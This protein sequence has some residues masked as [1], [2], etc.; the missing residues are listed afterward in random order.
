[1]SRLVLLTVYHVEFEED[2]PQP[3]MHI[4][5]HEVADWLY[6]LCNIS[7]ISRFLIEQ[8]VK[9]LGGQVMAIEQVGWQYAEGTKDLCRLIEMLGK[10][11][12]NNQI[13]IHRNSSGWEARGF[14][15]EGKRYWVGVYLAKPEILQFEFADAKPN[16]EAFKELGRGEFVDGKYVFR[17]QLDSEP[18]HFFARTKESQL[19]YLTEFVK[20]AYVDAGTCVE[21]K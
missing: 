2:D 8:F 18:I 12:E 5:W 7:P 1:M 17:V 21:V 16:I 9:F 20:N 19:E 10:A 13:R 11:L 6:G 4:R 15:T 14:Y 3:D